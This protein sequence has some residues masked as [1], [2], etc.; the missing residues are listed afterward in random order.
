[1]IVKEYNGY[2]IFKITRNT[3]AISKENDFKKHI[4]MYGHYPKTLKEAKAIIDNK[5]KEA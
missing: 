5:R 1:M 3:F 4:N 2:Y